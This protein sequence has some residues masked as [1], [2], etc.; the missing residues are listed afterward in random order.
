MFALVSRRLQLAR[1]AALRLYSTPSPSLDT[2]H[3]RELSD[4]ERNIH[5]K[6]LEKFS[7]TDLAVQDVSGG[8]GTFYAIKIASESFKGLSIIKQHRLVT[9]TLKAEIE[10]IHGLQIKTEVP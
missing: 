9:Q 6:L 5:N 8:C 4:G 1:P 10:G 3:T 7:P 2:Q